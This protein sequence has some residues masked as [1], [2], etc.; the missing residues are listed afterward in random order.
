MLTDALQKRENITIHY[1]TIPVEIRQAEGK[2][3]VGEIE[4]ENGYAKSRKNQQ[5]EHSNRFFP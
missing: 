4:V 5:T 1:D 3:M 2:P